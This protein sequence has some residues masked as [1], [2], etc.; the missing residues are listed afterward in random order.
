MT[1]A[2]S[3]IAS[4]IEKIKQDGVEAG[5]K[6][7]AERIQNAE[8]EAASILAKARADAQKIRE[9]AEKSAAQRRTQLEAE[10]RMAARDFG[11]RLQERLRK[12]VID[13]AAEKA[14]NEAMTDAATVTGLVQQLVQ[15]WGAAGG[16]VVVAPELREALTAALGARIGEAGAGGIEIVDEAGLK[17]FRL[18]KDGE[19]FAWDVSA[20][21]VSRELASLVEPG[22][23]FLLLPEPPRSPGS[24][25]FRA[26]PQDAED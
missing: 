12:Q 4:L 21:A 13:P 8:Q 25:K 20:E 23:R 19:H 5:E 16:R 11:F 17:G 9:D 10:L 7:R 15:G 18:L 26:V 2:T 14:A 24:G 3:G 1:Q 6:A 22:L